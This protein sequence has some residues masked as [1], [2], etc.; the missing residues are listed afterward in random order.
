MTDLSAMIG[1]PT[2]P[3]IPYTQVRSQLNTGD[4]FFLHGS[5][6]AG[7]MIEN[8]ER[9]KGWPEY[10]HCGMVIK[11][12]D[13]LYLWDAPGGGDCFP[14]PYA[15]DPDNRIHGKYAKGIHPGCRV[16]VLDDALA[17]YS[18]KTTNNGFWLRQ[19]Q[20]A[21]TAEKFGALRTFINRVD[22][23]PLP[24][25]FAFSGLVA[26]F[27]AGQTR[28]SLFFGTYF[29]TQLVADSYMH[30]GLLDMEVFPPNRYSPAAFA[31]DGT[32]QLPLVSPA[33]LGT[34]AFVSWDGKAGNAP[35]NCPD[36]NPPPAAH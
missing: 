35:C 26:N 1:L 22:G 2:S 10:S 28:A 19:L 15:D 12:G 6:Q 9:M 17:Y 32:N 7:V 20:P 24:P 16:S 29:C 18:T 27:T 3:S 23:L 30:M 8:L 13:N 21:V 31:L 33:T 36:F 4:L 25:G 14:D 34:V 11:D 5:S